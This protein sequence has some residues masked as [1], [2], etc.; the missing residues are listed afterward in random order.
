MVIC[1]AYPDWI[2]DQGKNLTQDR[3]YHGLSPSLCDALGF[4]IAELPKRDQVNMSFDTL[5]TL[6]KKMEAHQPSRPHGSSSGSS[7]A[8]RDKYRRHPTPMGRVASLEDEELFTPDPETWDVEPPKIDQIE[9]LSVRM[10]KAMNHYQW[11]ECRCFVC[12][13]MDHFAQDFP[14]H[15]TF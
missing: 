8:Y 14:H 1:H 10:T 13:T 2:S 6:A 7:K 9:G 5:Y 15:K 4:A 11:E 3:F 12:G